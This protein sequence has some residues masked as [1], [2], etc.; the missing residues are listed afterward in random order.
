MRALEFITGHVKYN[1]IPT[2]NHPSVSLAEKIKCVCVFFLI[3]LFRKLYE[4][5]ILQEWEQNSD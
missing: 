2:E 3:F 1:Q 5:R 4:H